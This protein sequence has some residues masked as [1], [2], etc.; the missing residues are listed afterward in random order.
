M[1]Q[2]ENNS[3]P[4]IEKNFPSLT[5]C[6]YKKICRKDWEGERELKEIKI[7]TKI[8]FKKQKNQPTKKYQ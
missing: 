5:K 6:I 8:G 1:N 2:K 7:F 3:D 4:G